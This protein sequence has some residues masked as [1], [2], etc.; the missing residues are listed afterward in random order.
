MIVPITIVPTTIGPPIPSFLETVKMQKRNVIVP[1][2]ILL[3]LG[4]APF[5]FGQLSNQARTSHRTLGYYDPATGAFQPLRPAMDANAVPAVTATTGTLVFKFTITVDSAIPKNGVVG[6]AADTSIS[7]SS[8][9]YSDEHGSGVATLV[10]GKT[11]DC[12]V[13]IPYSW[14]LSSASTDK[15]SITYTMTIDYGYQVTA[16]NGTGTL[17]EPVNDRTTEQPFG[18]ISVPTSGT[19]TTESISVTI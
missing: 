13:T 14:T 9:F 7:D 6:C 2:L 3:A 8:G 16:T 15:I 5:S 1:L 11:Y 10:S 18:E 17:V 12:T 4:L 19:T